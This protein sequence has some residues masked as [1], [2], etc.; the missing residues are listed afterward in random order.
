MITDD[1]SIKLAE[2][3]CLNQTIYLIYLLGSFQCIATMNFGSCGGEWRGGG[4]RIRGYKNSLSRLRIRSC[5]RFFL[6]GL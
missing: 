4:G 3:N 1:S 5:Q 2:G 6:F